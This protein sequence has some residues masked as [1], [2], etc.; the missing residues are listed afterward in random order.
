LVLLCLGLFT[1]ARVP[2][3]SPLHGIRDASSL[4]H[5]EQSVE[6]ASQAPGKD[7]SSVVSHQD[8]IGKHHAEHISVPDAASAGYLDVVL[9]LGS[10][11]CMDCKYGL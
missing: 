11:L 9:D 7:A 3:P 2:S 10:S 5:R 6:V 8:A 1:S 4:G